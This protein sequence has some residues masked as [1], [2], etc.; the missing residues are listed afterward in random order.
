MKLRFYWS[1]QFGR[2]EPACES[3]ALNY[4]GVSP[5]SSLLTDTGGLPYLSSLPWLDEGLRRL[6]TVKLG[7]AQ[8][9]GWAREDWGATFFRDRVN[10]YSLH[11]ESYAEDLSSD[12]FETTLRAWIEFIQSAPDAKAERTLVV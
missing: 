11:D 6:D 9:L 5:L 4:E 1:E 10:I 3:D 8:S 7:E 12:A 2:L